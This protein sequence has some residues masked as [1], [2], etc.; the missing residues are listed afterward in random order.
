MGVKS[1]DLCGRS[2]CHGLVPLVSSQISKLFFAP[3]PQEERSSRLVWIPIVQA[4]GV[5][6]N[7]DGGVL[8]AQRMLLANSPNKELM[9]FAQ[10]HLKSLRS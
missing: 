10:L 3:M 4:C 7:P 8:A 1:Y 6:K 5:F 9:H 2:G